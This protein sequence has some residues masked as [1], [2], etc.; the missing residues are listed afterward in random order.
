[1]RKTLPSP[2]VY[3]P[4]A[5]PLPKKGRF[6]GAAI[7]GGIEVANVAKQKVYILEI[8][9]LREERNF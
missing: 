5:N 9:G 2:H 6:Y 4:Y 3:K 7:H 1:M 8:D